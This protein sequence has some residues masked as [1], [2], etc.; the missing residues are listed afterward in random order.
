MSLRFQAD[1]DLNQLILH[2][3]IRRE[4]ARD[5]QTAAAAGLVGL[6]DPAVLTLE[7]DPIVKTNIAS[8]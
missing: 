8:Q 4:P 5:F 2:A 7:V 6:R 3:V 1:A